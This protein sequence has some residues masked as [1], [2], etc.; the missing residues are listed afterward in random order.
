MSGDISEW[1]RLQSLEQYLPNFVGNDIDLQ[2]LAEL[3]DADLT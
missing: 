2:L 1:L 3:T